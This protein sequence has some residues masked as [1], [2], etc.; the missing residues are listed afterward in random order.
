MQTTRGDRLFIR[1]LCGVRQ[2]DIRRHQ[3]QAGDKLPWT[4]TRRFILA[5][6]M[7][8]LVLVMRKG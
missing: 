5:V 1:L 2:S 6:S 3:R 7:L 4:L 8:V